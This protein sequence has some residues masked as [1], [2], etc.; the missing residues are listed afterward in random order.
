MA[1]AAQ[2]VRGYWSVEGAG[3]SEVKGLLLAQFERKREEIGQDI[4][5]GFPVF[6]IQVF[7]FE[8]VDFPDV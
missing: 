1:L 7:V 8:S 2:G 4:V 5:D 6:L 3:V